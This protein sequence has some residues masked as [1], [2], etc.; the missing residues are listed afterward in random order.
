M[1]FRQTLIVLSGETLSGETIRCAKCSSPVEKFVTF[2]RESFARY[3]KGARKLKGAK[4]EGARK[5]EARK[6]KAQNSK[7][8]EF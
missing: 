4:S 8:R 1:S 2:A 6:L 5:L 3:G 7:G